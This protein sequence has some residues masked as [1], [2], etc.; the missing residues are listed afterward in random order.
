MTQELQRRRRLRLLHMQDGLRERR[1]HLQTA[2]QARL[3]LPA[4]QQQ[5]HPLPPRHGAEYDHGHG[6][7]AVRTAQYDGHHLRGM[8]PLRPLQRRGHAPQRLHRLR[9]RHVRPLRLRRVRRMPR[10]PGPFSS[11]QNQFLC[12]FGR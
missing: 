9:V 10:R 12:S 8:H 1:L 2:V 6:L 11:R 4:A 3:R 5:V 7:R